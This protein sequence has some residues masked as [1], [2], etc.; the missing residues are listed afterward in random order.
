MIQESHLNCLL[1]FADIFQHFPL[2]I[3]IEQNFYFFPV[4]R[5]RKEFFMCFVT[6]NIW[7]HIHRNVPFS[8]NTWQSTRGK[9]IEKSLN[10]GMLSS[11]LPCILW[12][13]EFCISGWVSGT[14]GATLVTVRIV[15]FP[16][17]FLPQFWIPLTLLFNCIFKLTQRQPIRMRC[18]SHIVLG[19][20]VR[21]CVWRLESFLRDLLNEEALL[22]STQPVGQSII[23]Q[24]YCQASMRIQSA[25][26][27][28]YE[29]GN[30]RREG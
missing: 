28:S 7:V 6:Y 8:V 30:G 26:E 10:L 5:Y 11:G 18:S 4:A 13:S 12:L 3:P 16:R 20:D 1:F 27:C 9:E 19:L 23:W 17:K 24:E 14:L 21:L 29:L 22:Y 25:K 15:A 2:S